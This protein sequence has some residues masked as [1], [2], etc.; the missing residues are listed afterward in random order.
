MARSRRPHAGTALLWRWR[1]V[2]RSQPWLRSG[3]LA[4]RHPSTTSWTLANWPRCWIVHRL[5]CRQSTRSLQCI[6]LAGP[7]RRRLQ[8]AAV[9]EDCAQAHCA[10]GDG[11]VQLCEAL[12]SAGLF[13]NNLLV[14]ARSA[15][16]RDHGHRSLRLRCRHT[17]TGINRRRLQRPLLPRQLLAKGGATG[18][19][20]GTV[21]RRNLLR[22]RLRRAWRR[23]R[24]M[25]LLR[26][27]RLWVLCG[28]QAGRSHAGQEAKQRH[29]DRSRHLAT[30]SKS[31]RRSPITWMRYS[32]FPHLPRGIAR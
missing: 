19:P 5:A 27:C 14:A 18:C 1:R 11:V 9:V 4:R 26:R 24:R 13:R 7:R 30:T 2:P 25:Y 12:R 6:S 22:R 3:W 21:G 23:D 15:R 31:A 28:S 16:W 10:L 17:H 8:Q 32:A 29:S 20:R